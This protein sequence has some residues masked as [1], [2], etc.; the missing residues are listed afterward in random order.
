MHNVVILACWES[1]EIESGT[2]TNLRPMPFG[3]IQAA[4]W[5]RCATG[6]IWPW[7]TQE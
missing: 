4:S 3:S 1:I 7:P 6:R 2:V 5:R